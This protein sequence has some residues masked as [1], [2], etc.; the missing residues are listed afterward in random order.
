MKLTALLSLAP[1]AFSFRLNRQEANNVLSRNRR[2]SPFTNQPWEYKEPPFEQAAEFYLEEQ[3]SAYGEPDKEQFEKCTS[4]YASRYEKY[5]EQME[6]K[7]VNA[8]RP[9]YDCHIGGEKVDLVTFDKRWAKTN[10]SNTRSANTATV[11]ITCDPGYHVSGKSCLKNV[12][13]CANGE[14][15]EGDLCLVNGSEACVDCNLSW[16]LTDEGKCIRN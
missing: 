8:Q 6:K 15:A 4:I 14:N 1:M 7:V 10:F 12:C 16:R 9:E 13:T 11:A 5:D 2:W 3:A